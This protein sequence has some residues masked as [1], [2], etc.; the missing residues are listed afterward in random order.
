MPK[1][2]VLDLTYSEKKPKKK[3]KEKRFKAKPITLQ[4]LIE[5]EILP[6]IC[7]SVSYYL[8]QVQ[9]RMVAGK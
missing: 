4:E 6:V 5:K 8:R 3:G 1:R 9:L 2:K 7:L